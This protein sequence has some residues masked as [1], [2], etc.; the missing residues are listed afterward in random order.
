[1]LLSSPGHTSRSTVAVVQ[2]LNHV[3]LFCD[4]IDCSPSGSSVH[5]I[6]QARIREWMAISFSRGSTWLRD[7][8]WVSYTDKRVLYQWTT[9][10]LGFQDSLIK[11]R[12]ALRLMDGWLPSALAKAISL[13]WQEERPVDSHPSATLVG[14][15]CWASWAFFVPPGGPGLWLG[16]AEAAI[17]FWK[18][19]SKSQDHKLVSWG[20]M[21]LKRSGLW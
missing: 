13:L 6:F 10:F 21:L 19:R 14:Q 12:M 2:S 7:Q 18:F 11:T 8:L 3:R 15:L 9:W 1:M 20:A 17:T 4:C 5:E 16:E